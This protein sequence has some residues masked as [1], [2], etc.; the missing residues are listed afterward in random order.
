MERVMSA[1][2]L[3]PSQSLRN[4]NR[5]IG[6]WLDSIANNPERPAPP[7]PENMAAL[8]SELVRVGAGLRAQPLPL[9]GNDA[10][11]DRELDTYRR[12]VERLREVL[13]SIHTQLLVERARL[14][15]QWTRIH[16]ASQWARASR[17]TL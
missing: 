7:T 1:A 9:P 2:P 16:S 14:E 15:A 4:A 17:E 12:N 8:L 11:L 3:S 13:P 10:E 6:F 5:R